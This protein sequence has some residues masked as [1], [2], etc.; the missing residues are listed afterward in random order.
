MS[1]PNRGV[2][3]GFLDFVQPPQAMKKSSKKPT[4]K[5]DKTAWKEVE[6]EAEKLRKPTL[7]ERCEVLMA[8]VKEAMLAE[9]IEG[10][11]PL[12]AR[13]YLA[14][15]TDVGVVHVLDVLEHLGFKRPK[16]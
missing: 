2:K 7:K 1:G 9:E 12:D 16:R 14:G 13:V 8:E 3:C 5:K 15:R 6:L 10:G 11:H 4:K